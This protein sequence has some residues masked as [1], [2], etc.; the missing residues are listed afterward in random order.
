MCGSPC[1]STCSSQGKILDTLLKCEVLHEVASAGWIPSTWMG[2][3]FSPSQI[4]QIAGLGGDDHLF[5]ELQ[6]SAC[7][8]ERRNF[9][10]VSPTTLSSQLN[11]ELAGQAQAPDRGA[12]VS[13]VF[14]EVG[15]WQTVG[16]ESL[17]RLRGQQLYDTIRCGVWQGVAS[18][19]GRAA[20]QHMER[21]FSKESSLPPVLL[22]VE[23]WGPSM[24]QATD[25]LLLFVEV[26]GG[27]KEFYFALL[28]W[29]LPLGAP[30]VSTIS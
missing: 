29:S 9:S 26:T 4:P 17:C 2:K 30:A 27:P 1:C 20:T 22:R 14:Q 3:S 6:C 5:K 13:K 16:K 11:G 19:V 8:S 10:P 25:Q 18:A 21:I 23:E 28:G 12:G 24:L 7:G 15:R